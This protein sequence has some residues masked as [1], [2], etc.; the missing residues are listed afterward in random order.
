MKLP[1]QDWQLGVEQSAKVLELEKNNK[2]LLVC[3]KY[4]LH[5]KCFAAG[6]IAKLFL[7]NLILGNIPFNKF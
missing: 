2:Y 3:T 4:S 5:F 6:Y 1:L 7:P